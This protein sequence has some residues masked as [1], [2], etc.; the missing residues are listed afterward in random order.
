MKVSIIVPNLNYATYLPKCLDSIA[1]Q[2]YGDIEVLLADGGSTDGSI[3]ILEKYSEKYGWRIFSYADT[4]QVDVI[5]RGLEIASGEIHCWLNSDDVFLSRKSIET[6]VNIF[7]EV[8]DV[9]IVSLGGY[10]MDKDSKY[11]RPVKL[12]YHPLLR[13]TDLVYRLGG[14]LQPATFW[15]KEVFESIQLD[16]SLPYSFDSDFLIRASRQFN[17]LINQDCYIAGYRLHDSNL[18]V[19]VKY[20]RVL[21]LSRL[22]QK[23]LNNKFRSFYLNRLASIIKFAEF[24]PPPLYN[25]FTKFLYAI[26]NMM[27]Y[28][29]IYRIP[30]I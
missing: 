19:G 2:T 29:S 18:S 20:Q 15:K 21:E 30:S 11:T 27:S 13:Q 10:Y 6:I 5:S 24:L 16:V 14:L 1:C 23:L 9:E 17:L 12:Q 3:E 4:G 25:K 7:N 22:S 8:I 26:N 28:L